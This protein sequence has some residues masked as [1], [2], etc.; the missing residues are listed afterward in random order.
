MIFPA[1]VAVAVVSYFLL[2][3]E[4]RNNSE[5]TIMPV[6]LVNPDSKMKAFAQAIA[7]AEGFGI[8]GKIPSLANNPGDL[9]IPGWK[10]EKLGAEGISVFQTPEEGWN[11]LYYQLNLIVT[12]RSRIYNLNMNIL[13]MGARYAP[14][15]SAVWANNVAR[16]LRL[17]VYSSLREALT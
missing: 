9:V 14:H 8:P 3:R 1:L 16:A 2:R 13:E 11:R 12:G 7:T 15:D 5:V 6:K 10:G 4:E 17:S